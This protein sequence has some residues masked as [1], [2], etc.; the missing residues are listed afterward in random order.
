MEN[1][2]FW[3]RSKLCEWRILWHAT[4]QQQPRQKTPS[5]FNIQFNHFIPF[6]NINLIK[7]PIHIFNAHSTGR[8]VLLLHPVATIQHAD[9]NI[10]YCFAVP[11]CSYIYWAIQCHFDCM[12]FSNAV[13][14]TSFF[15]LINQRL[16]DKNLFSS[17][18]NNNERRKKNNTHFMFWARQ[19]Q[20]SNILCKMELC[21][22]FFYF[23]WHRCVENMQCSF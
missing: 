18:K 15:L 19:A 9:W 17:N 5:I 10:V 6:Q 8:F 7:Q 2:Y 16:T 21:W 22:S 4:Q 1:Y 11:V 23:Y 3:R 13:Y 14:V 20:F 12:L